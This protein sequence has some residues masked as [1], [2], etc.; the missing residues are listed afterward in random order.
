M[1][2]LGKKIDHR[3]SNQ[4]LDYLERSKKSNGLHVALD[5]D[6]SP[7]ITIGFSAYKKDKQ[8]PKGDLI[9]MSKIFFRDQL[10]DSKIEEMINILRREISSGS[11]HTWNIFTFNRGWPDIEFKISIRVDYE[12]FDTDL[13]RKEFKELQ[14]KFISFI[15]ENSDSILN[16]LEELKKSATWYKG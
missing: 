4:E 10:N 16:S 7:K 8:V 1:F 13:F 11:Q 9:G 2:G 14:E 6:F 12:H 3:Y 5:V 15:D